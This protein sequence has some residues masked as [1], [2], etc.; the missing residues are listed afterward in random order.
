M[1]FSFYILFLTSLFLFLSCDNSNSPDDK[2]DQNTISTDN[3]GFM[4]D[5]SFYKVWSDNSWEKFNSVVTIDNTTYVTIITESGF[6]YYYSKA[7]Y[8]GFK[9]SGESLILFNTPLG[10]LP[11]KL[12]FNQKYTRQTTFSIQ[13]YDFTMKIDEVLMDTVSISVPCGSF[14]SCLWFKATSTLTS[15]GQSDVSKSQ[16]WLAIGPSDI[17][18][19]LSSGETITMVGGIVNGQNWGTSG[20]MPRMNLCKKQNSSL[21]NNIMRPMI[22]FYK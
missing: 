6:E 21:L 19:T 18:Q 17:Q 10:S 9:P 8:A 7:G 12:A 1:R 15:G 16:F 13:G 14:S 20:A 22:R 5:E 4:L 11:D 3:Y 2:N